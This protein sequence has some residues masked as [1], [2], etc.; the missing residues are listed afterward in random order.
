VVPP[1]DLLVELPAEVPVDR[2]VAQECELK[3]AEDT[4]AALAAGKDMVVSTSAEKPVGERLVAVVPVGENTAVQPAGK[5]MVARTTVAVAAGTVVAMPVGTTA[6][7]PAAAP[8]GENAGMDTA[9]HTAELAAWGRL[10]PLVTVWDRPDLCAHRP[11]S[12]AAFRNATV[13]HGH[14][15][16]SLPQGFVDLEDSV[17]ERA[18]LK[19]YG[20]ALMAAVWA[21]TKHAQP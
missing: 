5:G 20:Q 7:V 13:L 10:A 12:F 21:A 4:T 15:V 8:V 9:A 2:V 3:A 1:L 18:V 6:V 19:P 11:K 14:S 17:V 16:G